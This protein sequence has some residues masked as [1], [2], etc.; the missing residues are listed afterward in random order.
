MKYSTQGIQHSAFCV[1]KT[2]IAPIKNII[3]WLQNYL[4]DGKL[5]P[6]LLSLKLNMVD[7]EANYNR[8]C[9]RCGL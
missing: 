2:N 1:I 7:D 3:S 8:K 4:R 6:K 5:V 9:R